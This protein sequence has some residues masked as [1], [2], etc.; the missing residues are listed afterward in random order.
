MKTTTLFCLIIL[1]SGFAN[2][3]KLRESE[4]PQAVRKA[5]AEKF[6]SV[7]EVKWSKEGTTEF[8]AEFDAGKQEKSANF[9]N[10][11]KW[12]V[13]ESEIKAAELPQP[14]QATI[15]REFAGYKIEEAEKAESSDKGSFFEVALTS[16]KNKYE[17]QLSAEGKVLKK[18]EV[19]EKG[20]K[21][22]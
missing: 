17:V 21:K 15:T 19:K 9:D 1:A 14:V 11:G 2:G 12:L 20:E 22:H 6:K 7:K 5:F 18:E 10:T 3:Q 8:E 16:G 13:T 4:V